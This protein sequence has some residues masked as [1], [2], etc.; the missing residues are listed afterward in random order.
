M[1]G[2]RPPLVRIALLGWMATLSGVRSPAANVTRP[3]IRI[4]P[5]PPLLPTPSDRQLAWHERGMYAFVHFNMNTFT[6]REWGD[7]TESP[8][9]FH[10]T[11]MDTDQWCRVFK[12][13]GMTGVIVTA[14][15]HDG[16]C[17]WPS[18][19]TD[20]DVE[21]TDWRNGKGDVLADLSESCR[22]F[23]L[24]FGVEIFARRDPVP[25]GFVAA[26]VKVADPELD[27]L[28]EA[29][30]ASLPAS[31]ISRIQQC[32]VVVLFAY[33]SFGRDPSWK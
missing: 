6:D 13:A 21:S 9:T 1:I 11:A 20:H 33:P 10:P 12:D 4:D 24:D 22:R 3:E 30:Q 26:R 23:G 16:F 14:K 8:E 2:S 28:D 25:V 31:C 7:G 32:V 18:A 29:A 27:R 5:P 17:L 19:F 15:H